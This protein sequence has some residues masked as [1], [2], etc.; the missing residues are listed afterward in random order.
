MAIAMLTSKGTSGVTGAG[1][2]TLAATLAIVPDI[3]IQALAILVGIDKF[4]SECRALI[5]VIGKGVAAVLSRLEG[6]LDRAELRAVM[7]HPLEVGEALE[8]ELA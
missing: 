1:F 5:N 3:P 6:E 7:A 8:N 4:K 2:V